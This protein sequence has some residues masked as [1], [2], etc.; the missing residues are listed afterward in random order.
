[1]RKGSLAQLEH[2]SVCVCV[3][4]RACVKDSIIVLLLDTYCY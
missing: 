3:W 2:V 4:V 1:M